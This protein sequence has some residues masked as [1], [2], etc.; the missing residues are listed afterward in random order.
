MQDI[1]VSVIVPIHGVDKFLDQCL[2]SL[3]NQKFDYKY[4]VICVN[5]T[6]NDNSP[7]IIDKYVNLKNDVF[8]RLDVFNRNVSYTRN[9][10]L[11]AASGDYVIFIDGD[12]FVDENLLQI[13]YQNAIKNDAEVVIYNFYMYKKGKNKRFFSSFFAPSGLKTSKKCIKM[14]MNDIQLRS[15][16]RLKFVKRSLLIDNNIQFISIKKVLEDY[17]YS[18]MVLTKANRIS[19]IK[20][21]LYFYRF[22]DNS[23]TNTWHNFHTIQIFLSAYA[24]TKIYAVMNN[25]KF[26]FPSF[27]K[28]YFLIYL[29]FQSIHSENKL[30][31]SIAFRQILRQFWLIKK[32]IVYT[33]APWEEEAKIVLNGLK[34][35]ETTT[36]SKD[37]IFEIN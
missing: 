14:L 3:L 7:Q 4:E 23:I 35:A 9:D 17:T 1:K 21:R 16:S 32:E 31:K 15:Y 26:V 11:K 22:S 34:L 8:K 37:K 19:C 13:L 10:G 27:V 5:D 33:N 36:I 29:F 18:F 12:D 20:D 25:T 2:S 6:P 24:I 28:L 30:K